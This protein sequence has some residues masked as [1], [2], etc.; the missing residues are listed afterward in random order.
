MTRIRIDGQLFE[1]ADDA[2]AERLLDKA[3]EAAR[4]HKIGKVPEITANTRRLRSRISAAKREIASAQVDTELRQLFA[5]AD[6]DEL[7]LF[8]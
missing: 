1:C 2:E 4:T 3:V 6:N 5:Q 7:I 8:L